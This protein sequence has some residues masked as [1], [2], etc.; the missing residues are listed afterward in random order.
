[1]PD[2]IL[3]DNFDSGNRAPES[4]NPESNSSGQMSYGRGLRPYI[5]WRPH[6]RELPAPWAPH[7]MVPGLGSRH[8]GKIVELAY[9]FQ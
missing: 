4:Q 6:V 5:R 8:G 7:G 3:A 9:D 1:M 2:L